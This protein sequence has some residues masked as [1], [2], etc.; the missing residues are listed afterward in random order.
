MSD[1]LVEVLK[2]ELKSSTLRILEEEGRV[3]KLLS[4]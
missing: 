3:L 4:L 2:V 1:N